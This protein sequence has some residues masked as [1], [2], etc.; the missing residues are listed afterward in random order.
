MVVATEINYVTGKPGMLLTT[1]SATSK[2]CMEFQALDN[3]TASIILIRSDIL[4]KS[5]IV[6]K[7]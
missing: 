5:F 1:T 3:I 2:K 6:P 7:N 4:M